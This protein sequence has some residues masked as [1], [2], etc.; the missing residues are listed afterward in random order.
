MELPVKFENVE[1]K[2][3]ELRDE[4]VILDSDVAALYAVETREIN[5]A[6]KNNPEKFPEGYV[7]KLTPKEWEPVKSKFLTSPR[8]G[9]KVKLPKAFTEKGLYMLATI[10]KGKR[11]TQTTLT[12]IE[13]F[14]RIRNITNQNITKNC[15]TDIS[16]EVKSRIIRHRE[17]VG[18]STRTGVFPFAVFN[19]VKVFRDTFF[20]LNFSRG[21]TPF[22]V[23]EFQKKH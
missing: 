7:M 18:G 1:S 3:I 20:G 6:V 17:T 2:I 11:A 12:I 22:F 19:C 4:Y 15:V 23:T 13:T 16:L 8:G 9:G 10:I 21:F 14:A 5:Q